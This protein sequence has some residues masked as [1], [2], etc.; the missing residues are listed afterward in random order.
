MTS[1][2]P[3]DE[4]DLLLNAYADGELDA[5][6]AKRFEARLAAEPELAAAHER[7]QGLRGL[8]REDM[9]DDVPPEALRRKIAAQFARPAQSRL[10]SWSALAAALLI[11][12]VV[13]GGVT[14]VLLNPGRGDP[15]ADQIVAAHIRALMAPQPIDVASS[16]RHTVKPWFDGKLAFAPEV[17]DLA[18]QGFPLVGGRLDVVDLQPVPAL[19]YRAGKHLISVVEIPGGQVSFSP[20]AEKID[21]GYETIRW[22]DGKAT[23]WAVSD[24]SDA[25]MQALVKALV[26]ATR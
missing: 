2:D 11:G 1:P 25:E 17:V 6:A 26:E 5:V 21:R 14:I 19:V 3:Q 23:W 10:A 24:A 16:D 12:I 20:P 8:L 22:S 15:I 4:T 7:L 9:A 13:G 18:A